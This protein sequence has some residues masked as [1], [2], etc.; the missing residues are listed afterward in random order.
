MRGR[1]RAL[2]LASFSF[3]S[4]LT[5]APFGDFSADPQTTWLTAP[6]DSQDRRMA[7][8]RDFWYKDPAGKTWNAPKGSIVDGAS[9]PAALWS[10]VGSPYTGPYRRASVVHDVACDEAAHAADPGAARE[11]ADEMF[12][13]ACRAGGCPGWQ[14][15]LLYLGVRVG[16]TWPRL[17]LWNQPVHEALLAT[18]RIMPDVPEESIRTTYREIAAAIEA[19][20]PASFEELKALVD[21]HLAARPAPVAPM[22]AVRSQLSPRPDLDAPVPGVKARKTANPKAAPKPRAKRTPSRKP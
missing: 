14:A 17:H 10:T 9:I 12:Y 18:A 7:L 1:P 5:M 4:N 20:A 8:L 19:T 6:A 21:Q 16:A 2:T 15:Q 22:A 11:A 3:L 13:N